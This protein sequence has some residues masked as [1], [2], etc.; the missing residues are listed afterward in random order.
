MVLTTTVRRIDCFG[1]IPGVALLPG[2]EAD[3][4]D[5]DPKSIRD[6][7]GAIAPAANSNGMLVVSQRAQN[8]LLHLHGAWT[9]MQGVGVVRLGCFA[10]IDIA[11]RTR[12]WDTSR[13]K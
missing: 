11:T 8:Q 13:G 10:H 4:A 12:R 3:L 9:G 6:G 1:P 7:F 5:H 2:Q